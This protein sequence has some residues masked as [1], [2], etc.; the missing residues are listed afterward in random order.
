MITGQCRAGDGHGAC[1]VDR[2]TIEGLIARERR[3]NN[4]HS[5]GIA[6]GTTRSVLRDVVGELTSGNK[7]RPSVIDGCTP[8]A[9]LAIGESDL[10]QEVGGSSGKGENRDGTAATNRD[11]TVQAPADRQVIRDRREWRNQGDRAADGK[12]N[13]LV[14]GGGIGLIDDDR[15]RTWAGRVG[16][17]HSKGVGVNGAGAQSGK[18]A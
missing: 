2:S 6:D 10:V 11:W 14:A 12:L 18:Q 1:I 3:R 15:K 9:G 8:S 5:P 13:R 17:R 16:P 4:R 7:Q